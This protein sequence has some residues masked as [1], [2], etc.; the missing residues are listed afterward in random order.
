MISL[1]DECKSFTPRRIERPRSAAEVSEAVTRAA[2]AGLRV[3]PMGLGY[4]WSEQTFTDDVSL[5]M[6]AMRHRCRID[7]STGRVTVDA[8]VRIGDMTRALAARG[9]CLPSLAFLP[10]MTAGG[11]VATATHGTNHRAGTISDFVTALDIVVAS[12]E[13][14]HF[15][16]ATVSPE[17]M[18]AARVAV[19]MLGV[20]T[21]VEFQAVEMPWVRF[22]QYDLALDDF[23]RDRGA[24]FAEYDHI[25]AHWTLGADR[26]RIDCL[27]KS[28]TP[29]P[30]AHPYVNYRNA[31]WLKG[32]RSPLKDALK[33]AWHLYQ[34]FRRPHIPVTRAQSPAE[35]R[36][37]MQYAVPNRDWEAVVAAI[38]A[39]GF[40]RDNA[41]QIMEM[42]FVQG[43]DLSFLGPNAGQDAVC[44]NVYWMVPRDALMVV[45]LPFEDIMLSFNARPHWGKDH[46]RP[47]AGY[48]ARALPDWPAFETVR[49]RLDP[50]DMFLSVSPISGRT[51]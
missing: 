41:G 45:L 19:G 33:P 38:R 7:G 32:P 35:A 39:S 13:V 28:M 17:E 44:F 6:D 23:M 46:R 15:S 18:R 27:A 36:T 34:D 48:L 2:Q 51:A 3:R 11:A 9:L 31:V 21:R 26:V 43:N 37:S 4:S 14:K 5:R 16:P 30:D 8:G 25:W 24:I 22:A 12:G 40:A 20:I 10:E 42:K 47:D 50:D 29:A 1:Y 49:K